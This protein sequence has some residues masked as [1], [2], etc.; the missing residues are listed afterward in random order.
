MQDS[1]YALFLRIS[2]RPCVVVGGGRVAA[3][4]VS[5]L[6]HS[7]AAVTVVSPILCAELDEQVAL[8]KF[9]HVS[10]AFR[11]NDTLGAFLTF[12][13][14][15]DRMVNESVANEVLAR[16]GLVNVADNP[17]LCSFL[18]PA[19]WQDQ[20]LQIA[21]STGGKNPSLAKRLRLALEEDMHQP[22]H[23]SGQGSHFLSALQTE[24]RSSAP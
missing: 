10:R 6:L 11:P 12:A 21:I 24:R 13:A 14:T 5:K 4:K 20:S 18:V 16:G 8:G 3:R 22:Q 1:E 15:D 7:G 23:G 17:E 2:G 9:T 19:T